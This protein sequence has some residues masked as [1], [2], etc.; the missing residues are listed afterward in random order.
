MDTLCPR[1]PSETAAH[2]SEIER[3]LWGS[4]MHRDGSFAMPDDHIHSCYELFYL[5]Q[6]H[7]RMF[8]DD[9]FY[10]L[11]PGCGLLLP[12]GILHH[13]V[14][15]AGEESLRYS[16]YFCAPLLDPLR[17]C[18]PDRLARLAAA[19]VQLEETAR[20]EAQRLLETLLE[21]QQCVDECSLLL[22]R[23]A[24]DQMLVLLMRQC[25]P[26]LRRTVSPAP[27]RTGGWQ[28]AMV[29]DTIHYLMEHF[30]EP[31]SLEE[32]AARVPASPTYFSKCF[33]K[34]TGLGYR[35]YL[36]YIRIREA[37]RLLTETDLPIR[38]VARRCG[39]TSS[40]YFGDVFSAVA[41]CSPR[42]YR[43]GH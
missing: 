24:L 13:T 43:A 41:G 5:A 14:Y 19:P 3:C 6:G 15:A 37:K 29:Q 39:Y 8:V 35:E 16:F 9:A 31:I 25:C 32:L 40:N 12:P 30:A 11:S 23:H 22:C 18:A 2:A 4:R 36:I 28:E 26:V 17:Q 38:E 10:T 42:Q 20:P 21:E 33:K 34:A 27:H 7:C 1:R